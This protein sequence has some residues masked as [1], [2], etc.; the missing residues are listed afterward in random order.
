MS[1]GS[2]EDDAVSNEVP[3][4]DAGRGGA[5]EPEPAGGETSGGFHG[6]QFTTR[7]CGRPAIGRNGAVQGIG[8]IGE[9]VV[10]EGFEPPKAE[11]PDLQSGPVGRLGTPPGAGV[12]YPASR[13]C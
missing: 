11:P 7:Y 9:I 10:G 2:R 3:D 1:L 12:V 5:C 8:P 13:R 4:E 6:Y